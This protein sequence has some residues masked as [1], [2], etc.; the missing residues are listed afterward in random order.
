MTTATRKSPDEMAGFVAQ[1]REHPDVWMKYPV[2]LKPA[3]AVSRAWKIRSGNTTTFGHGFETDVTENGLLVRYVTGPKA[4]RKSDAKTGA[5][6]DLV[7]AQ[8][9]N[10]MREHVGETVFCTTFTGQ[11]RGV[12]VGIDGRWALVQFGESA[13]VTKVCPVNLTLPRDK[14]DT[15]SPLVA[16]GTTPS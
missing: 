5:T 15:K 10:R 1:L 8:A 16:A 14:P 2:N 3:S 6:L 4:N 13:A 11:D 12:L 9:L 7:W